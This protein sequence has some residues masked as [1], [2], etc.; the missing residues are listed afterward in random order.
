[1]R[2]KL[3][4]FGLPEYINCE[5]PH[6]YP[7]KVKLNFSFIVKGL[8]TQPVLSYYPKYN[9]AELRLAFQYYLFLAIFHGVIIFYA[10]LIGKK[11]DDGWF[12]ASWR[13]LFLPLYNML[14]KG[15]LGNYL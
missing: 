14:Y 12:G 6:N 1:M 3:N 2:E 10:Y 4:S 5:S 9:I 8:F 15:F 11:S 7:I 13:V